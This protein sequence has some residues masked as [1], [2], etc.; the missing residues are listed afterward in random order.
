M[1]S[2]LF[3]LRLGYNVYFYGHNNYFSVSINIGISKRALSRE[4]LHSKC[5]NTVS[6]DLRSTNVSINTY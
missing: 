2:G 4:T 3:W 6:A 5:L 1:C